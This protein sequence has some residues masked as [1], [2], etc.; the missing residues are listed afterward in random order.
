[1]STASRFALR[2]SADRTKTAGRLGVSE[3]SLGRPRPAIPKQ[4]TWGEGRWRDLL[5]RSLSDTSG[6]FGGITGAAAG[7]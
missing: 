6:R 5:E 7:A 4:R 3:P 1:M 2:T